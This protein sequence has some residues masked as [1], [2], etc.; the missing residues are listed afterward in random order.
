MKFT[1]RLAHA[2]NAF[3]DRSRKEELITNPWSPPYEYG[4][5]SRPDRSYVSIGT[6]RTII[7]SIYTRLAI[8]VA[9]VSIQH[10]KIDD[11]G[12]YIEPI[13]SGLND[14]LTLN[15][16]K[17]QTGRAFIQDVAMSMFDEGVVAV[18]P[19]DTSFNPTNSNM[20][21]ILSMRT[22][23]IQ[24]WFPDN[25][26]V[27][28]YNDRTGKREDIKLPKAMVAIIENPLYYVMNEPNST[29]QR[30]SK[31]LALM[32]TVDEATASNKLDIIIQLPYVIKNDLKREQAEQRRKDIEMQLTSSKYGVAYADG[33]EK[34]IQLGRQIENQMLPTVE[35]L[36]SMLYS[37]L[38]LTEEIMK[39][40]ATEEQMLNYYNRTIEPILGAIAD[41]MKRK[42]L[43]KNAIS[44]HQTI[45]YFR[46]PFRLAPVNQIAEIADKFTRN[47]ILSSNEL[48]SIVGYKQ[49]DDP[50]ANELRNKNL[51]QG[52]N[53]TEVPTVN[54]LEGKESSNT[55]F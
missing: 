20:Y 43:S 53:E 23:K 27:N 40:T 50:Q 14:C 19:V 9:A 48:R 44:R 5:F 6:E 17:D 30:L 49:I 28:V 46:D 33:T 55:N 29:V 26:K 37:Q 41:E 4:S 35:Y 31:K 12:G 45:R 38:G 24:E 2:W 16:N 32:D 21:D 54:P 34:I 25:V 52:D 51:N 22:G 10:C 47:A 36:T 39:G 18:V 7:S 1:E 42:F 3:M 11:N 13:P 15:A 8:D